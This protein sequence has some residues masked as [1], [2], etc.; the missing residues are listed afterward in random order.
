MKGQLPALFIG[1]STEGLSTAYAIQQ[2]LDYDAEP[3]VWSQGLF[4]PSQSVL[5]ELVAN[6]SK[7]EFAVFVFSPDDTIKLRGVEFNSV[8]DNVIFELGLFM[9]ALGPRRCFYLIPRNVDALHLP[10]DLAGIT[11]LTYN[12]A[13][14]DGN[15]LA[16]LGPACNDIRTA[17]K[18]H[19]KKR[20]SSLIQ[21]SDHIPEFNSESPAEKLRRY[22][23]SWNGDVLS[24]ARDQIRSNKVP[25]SIHEV[26]PATLPEWNA[27]IRVFYFMESLSA[28]ILAGEIDSEAAKT[29]FD[30]ALTSVW[31]HASTAL[32]M[33]NHAEES[34]NPLPAIAQVS[35]LWQFK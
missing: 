11:P 13:R 9:G 16:A 33:P 22:L 8:R 31:Q 26:D 30:T 27:F 19:A 5:S 25:M 28:A 10:S 18:Q 1:S 3:T 24:K 6:L 4:Q 20:A 21:A 32:A 29:L 2:A 15:M 17:I 7:F 34:W 14:S 23:N 35:K 12:A